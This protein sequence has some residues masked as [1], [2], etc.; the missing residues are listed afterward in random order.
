MDIREV[1]LLSLNEDED[2]VFY[3]L[4]SESLNQGKMLRCV[5][6]PSVS[7]VIDL[8]CHHNQPAH[9]IIGAGDLKPMC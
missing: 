8:T 5:H 1:H 3:P 4:V 7:L 9:L 6:Y 2:I